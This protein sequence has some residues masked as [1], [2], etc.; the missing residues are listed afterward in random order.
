[1]VRHQTV[2]KP[3]PA[4]PA[5]HLAELSE[6]ALGIAGVEEDALPAIPAICYVIDAVRD[7]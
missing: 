7:L 5:D 4:E 1:V 6:E 2:G 3:Q